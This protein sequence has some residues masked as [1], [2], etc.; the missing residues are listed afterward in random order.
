MMFTKTMIALLTA[1]VLSVAYVPAQAQSQAQT[2]G[3][4][5]VPHTTEEGALS[6]YPAWRVC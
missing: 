2:Q 4:G 3:R 1:L 6:A 5:C